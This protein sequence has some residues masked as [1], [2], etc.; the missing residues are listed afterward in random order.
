MGFPITITH[1][2]DGDTIRGTITL[3]WGVGLVD[4]PIRLLGY[5][6]W[7]MHRR[8]GREEISP[9][10]VAKGKAARDALIGL[11]R[12]AKAAVVENSHGTNYD[13]YGR[14]LAS[15]KLF[16][17]GD[18]IDVATWMTV[19]KHC[20][21]ERSN[22]PVDVDSERRLWDEAVEVWPTKPVVSKLLWKNVKTWKEAWH[23]GICFRIREEAKVWRTLEEQKVWTMKVWTM[24]V[25]DI[26]GVSV[27][28]IECCDLQGAMESA[29][30]IIAMFTTVEA[31]GSMRSRLA[32]SPQG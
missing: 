15:L 20:R 29:E 2:L 4:R 24:M 21:P 9:E 14:V 7:E 26:N 10:E 31:S 28:K 32:A 23:N 30:K 19:S 27:F 1:V 16:I 22:T 8:R 5:D 12:E 3:P 17:N 25:F 18:W 11:V 13:V 6:A